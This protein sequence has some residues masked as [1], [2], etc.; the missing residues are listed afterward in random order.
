MTWRHN[1]GS[2]DSD[3]PKRK[4]I[5]AKWL[6]RHRL[7]RGGARTKIQADGN[8]NKA[9]VKIGYS[10]SRS[11]VNSHYATGRAAKLSAREWNREED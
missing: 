1:N 9:N 6:N 11:R 5:R 7:T 8:V 2:D 3:E 4:K 10:P